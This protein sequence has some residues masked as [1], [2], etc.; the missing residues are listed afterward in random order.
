M[1]NQDITT[2]LKI[3]ESSSVSPDFNEKMF[4]WLHLEQ[5]IGQGRIRLDQK[6]DDLWASV[7]VI[8]DPHFCYKKCLR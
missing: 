3:L 2:F 1:S 6:P 7:K 5:L 8:Y 4:R